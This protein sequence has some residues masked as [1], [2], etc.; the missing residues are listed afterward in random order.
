MTMLR[1]RIGRVLAARSPREQRL[2]VAAMLTI[3]VGGLIL[4]TEWAVDTRNSLDRRIPEGHGA[5]ARMLEDAGELNRLK[6]LPS[7]AAV[8]LA[9]HAQSVAAAAASRSLAMTVKVS[10]NALDVSGTG[11]LNSILDWLASVQVDQ[12]LLPRRVRMEVMEQGV[13]ID[14]VLVPGLDR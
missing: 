5:L 13:R 11:S 6:R 14:A 2:L 7:P 1:T 10:G 4:L 12:Q 3:A 9:T 8:S